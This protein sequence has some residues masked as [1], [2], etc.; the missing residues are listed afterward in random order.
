VTTDA[1]QAAA[2]LRDWLEDR[3]PEVAIVLGSGLGGFSTG[4][5]QARTLSY[6]RL[7]GFPESTVAGH[8][9][10]FV[11]GRL[12]GRDI[13]VQCGRFHLYEGYDAAT[14]ALPVRLMARI[15]IR[16]LFITN[17]AGGID[18]G[19]EPG[20]L[21]LIADQV[22]L[23]FRNALA[24]P[25]ASGES[26]FPDMSDPYD[27]DLRR[28]A[29]QVARE[30]QIGVREGVYAGVLGP[31]YE[32]PAEIRMLR[33]LGADAVGMSTV[34]EVVVARAL[35]MRCAGCSIITNRAAGLGAGRLTHVEV[36]ERAQQAG[37]SLFR[38]L[39]GMLPRFR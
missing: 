2:R 35:G 15:G 25:V 11:V 24:G 22:N 34:L 1:G 18:A 39:G 37:A 38:L 13:L 30:D 19:L 10:Q 16:T 26:R 21:M 23:S 12:R 33:R 31:S 8:A 5:E 14:V 9:G 17:A 29:R 27:D 3:Q 36:L 28:L 6:A 32:T 4:L 20:Q 7:P